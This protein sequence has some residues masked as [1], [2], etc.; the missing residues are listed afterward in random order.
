MADAAA[1]AA[2]ANCLRYVPSW[3][4]KGIVWHCLCFNLLSGAHKYAMQEMPESM[5][6]ILMFKSLFNITLNMLFAKH[7][8]ALLLQQIEN[9]AQLNDN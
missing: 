4:P 6:Q 7:L 9:D 8:G 3:T 5:L 2:V 1:A